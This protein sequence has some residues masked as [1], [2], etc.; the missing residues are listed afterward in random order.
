MIWYTYRTH[1]SLKVIQVIAFVRPIPMPP[2]SFT[3]DSVNCHL[4]SLITV[5]SPLISLYPQRRTADV[6]HYF[7]L[8][9][10]C[11]GFMQFDTDLAGSGASRG[12]NI[13]SSM[14]QLT[15]ESSGDQ[16]FHDPWMTLL[17]QPA[18]AYGT[19]RSE[20]STALHQ[21]VL[22]VNTSHNFTH[23]CTPTHNAWTHTCLCL[24]GFF[25]VANQ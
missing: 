8:Q 18:M 16:T 9:R 10:R 3:L 12:G 20:G 19:A 6:A 24:V 2:Y 21:P 17:I 4:Y 11:I 22:A 14:L 1:C 25:Y 15:S 23:T 13:D 5:G 7:A